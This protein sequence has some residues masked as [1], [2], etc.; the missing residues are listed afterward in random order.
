MFTPIYRMILFIALIVISSA[1]AEQML[2]S[3]RFSHKTHD[4][5]NVRCESCH[6]EAKLPTASD[7]NAATGWMPLKPSRIVFPYKLPE[8]ASNTEVASVPII[9]GRPPE[10]ICLDCHLKTKR[11]RDCALCHLEK[12]GL[13]KRTRMRL[14]DGVA[15][16][17]EKHKS[18]DCL[19]CHPKINDWE[20]LDGTMQ[21]T[22]ME[23]CL[24]CHNGVKAKKKC[25]LCHA[26]VPHPKDHTRNYE[27][28]HGIAY[29]SDPLKC[30]MCHEDSSCV[31]CHAQKPRDHSL[32]W[33]SRGHGFTAKSNPDKCAACHQTRDICLRCHDT[34]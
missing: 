4:Y 16:A 12:P 31:E 2:S 1:T 24:I 13:T 15:F 11:K 6:K 22:S 21:D 17:H 10:K 33:V 26:E 14:K 29:R 7:D 5:Q 23:S 9:F 32:A 18:A 3:L 34:K 30:R 19:D 27:K 25:G 28:K 8:P 20:T